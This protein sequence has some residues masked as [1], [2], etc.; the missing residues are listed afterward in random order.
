MK[1]TYRELEFTIVIDTGSGE[2]QHELLHANIVTRTHANTQ[3]H[4]HTHTQTR[5]HTDPHTHTDTQIQTHTQKQIHIHTHT[6]ACRFQG[7]STS[8]PATLGSCNHISSICIL[9]FKKIL[10]RS[11]SEKGLPRPQLGHAALRDNSFPRPQLGLQ[12]EAQAAWGLSSDRVRI[13]LILARSAGGKGLPR[14]QLGHAARSAG[15]NGLPRP[16]LGLRAKRRRQGAC[17]VIG[18]YACGIAPHPPKM[19]NNIIFFN[20]SWC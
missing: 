19:M 18:L 2:S 5:T 1:H 4:T 8:F 6:A 17:P 14:P 20:C 15:D 13:S 12:R 10:A 9:I 7:L 3:R 16:Q 11:A